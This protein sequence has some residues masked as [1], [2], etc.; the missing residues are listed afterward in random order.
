MKA[1]HKTLLAAGIALSPMVN[2]AEL[3]A[4]V[5][6][7]S[8]EQPFFKQA[9]EVFNQRYASDNLSIDIVP[10]PGYNDALQ[11]AYLSDDLPDI[12]MVDGPN[13]AS[14]VWA[15]QLEPLDD[16]IA[17]EV[18]AD[19]LQPI[20]DQGTYSPDGKMY[21][22]GPSDSSV[23]LWGNRAYLE[24]ANV[25]I[26]TSIEDA[27]TPAE[28]EA[29]LA[30]LAKLDEVRWPLDLKRNYD[31]E[32][33]TYGFAPFIQSAGADLINRETWRATGTLNSPEAVAAL[34]TVQNWGT[35][36]WLVPASAGDNAFFGAKSAAL[37]WVGNWMWQAHTQGLGDD[38]VILPAPRLGAELATPNGGWGWAVPAGADNQDDIAKFLN[39]V[40]S[41]EQIAI[42]SEHTG[43]IPGRESAL[44][45]SSLYGEDGQGTIFAQQAK[46][47]AVVRPVHPAYPVISGEFTQA[48]KTVLDGGDIKSA[49][50]RAAS[51]IDMDIEDNMGYP[52]FGQ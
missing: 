30:A 41:A 29:A 10:I 19:M 1:I 35:N 5:I 42:W 33:F 13:M 25:R 14:M 21:L 40:L 11:S 8:A 36:G 22:A 43:Y 23:V 16:L 6:D 34:Q 9:E 4:W 20:K 48:I 26:P 3:T 45:L 18:L 38:L 50:D 39:F 15:G 37:S 52:P 49:L 32:W 31:G 7:G 47:T 44:K 46:S 24:K 17:P 51:R 27:W 2:A 12:I 28:F